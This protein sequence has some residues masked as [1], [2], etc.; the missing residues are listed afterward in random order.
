MNWPITEALLCA[1]LYFYRYRSWRVTWN[2]FKENMFPLPCFFSTYN[3]R[4]NDLLVT[5]S[6]PIYL[7]IAIWHIKSA[8][9]YKVFGRQLSE[10]SLKKVQSKYNRLCLRILRKYDTCMLGNYTLR[11]SPMLGYTWQVYLIGLPVQNYTGSW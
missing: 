9:I 4:S 5:S 3:F 1:F 8:T 2:A 10:S 11:Q 6:M 7:T